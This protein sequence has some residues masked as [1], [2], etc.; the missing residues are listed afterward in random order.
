VKLVSF[1][2]IFMDHF[3]LVSFL[4]VNTN[5]VCS[6]ICTFQMGFRFN[7]S[8]LDLPQSREVNF[9]KM[10]RFDIGFY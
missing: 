9:L 2:L 10:V 7:Y 6:F 3:M 8:Q 4:V 1:G 5:S